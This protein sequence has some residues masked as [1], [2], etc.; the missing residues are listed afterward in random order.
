L[1]SPESIVKNLRKAGIFYLS[2]ILSL[3]RLPAKPRLSFLLQ[4]RQQPIPCSGERPFALTPE[5]FS[6][7]ALHSPFFKE[8]G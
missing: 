8:S 3:F 7:S 5:K 4:A 1:H 6:Q 2:D